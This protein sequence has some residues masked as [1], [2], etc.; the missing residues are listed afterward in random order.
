MLIHVV[1]NSNSNARSILLSTISLPFQV[2]SGDV[3]HD[4][5]QPQDHKKPLR[6]RTV[7]DTFSITAS[8]RNT[9]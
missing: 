5:L 1:S 7:S 2:D 9:N 4:S 6:E 8:L 3:E